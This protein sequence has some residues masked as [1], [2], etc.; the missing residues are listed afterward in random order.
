MTLLRWLLLL[1]AVIGLASPAHADDDVKEQAREL[2]HRAGAAMKAGD[3]AA[4]AELY[5]ES[6]TL[7]P[8]PTAALGHARALVKLGKLLSAAERYTLLIET[9]L[10]DDPPEVFVEAVASAKKERELVL[11]RVPKLVI[12]LD[13]EAEITL[14]GEPLP[15]EALGI[16]RLVDPGEHVVTATRD[17][18]ELTQREVRVEE[19]QTMKV[20]LS[21]PSVGAYG[22]SEAS[23]SG[24][25]VGAQRFT[26]Y[27]LLGLGGAGTLV[28]AISGGLYLKDRGTVDDECDEDGLCS[29]EGLDAVDGA[30]TMGAVNTASL[31]VALV[32]TG[33]GLTLVL[34]APDDDD[35]A[36]AP[37]IGPGF[38][39]VAGRF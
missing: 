35:V 8:A 6:N 30:R 26:G 2:F 3:Y 15:A 39:G 14:D 21:V 36:V 20:L 37:V 1:T 5:D 25:S 16:E 19:G 18:E 28:F 38:V 24:G 29:Q 27:A 23:P 34:T 22:D 11:P 9:E 12:T 10:G 4:A 32:A 33:A 7:Y 13:G 31:I 17:G